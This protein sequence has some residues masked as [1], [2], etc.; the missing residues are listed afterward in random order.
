M[1]L[2]SFTEPLATAR[3]ASMPK[4]SICS[5]F[6]TSTWKPYSFP[7]SSALLASSSGI[8]TL[9]G[10]F[11]KFLATIVESIII[12]ASS[13]AFSAAATFSSAT[14]AILTSFR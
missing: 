5:L 7:K 10:S 6:L 13:N 8:R 4:A 3:Y 12:L 1:S 14:D 2:G 9:A 11:T